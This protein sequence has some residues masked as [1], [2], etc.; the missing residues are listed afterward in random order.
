[1]AKY[2]S[3]SSKFRANNIT[4]LE[5]WILCGFMGHWYGLTGIYGGY[6]FRG[7]KSRQMLKIVI[8][9]GIFED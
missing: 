4:E 6:F 3:F 1:M 5:I 7:R 2:M 8:L 9:I